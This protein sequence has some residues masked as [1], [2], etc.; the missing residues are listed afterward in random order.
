MLLRDKL[1]TINDHAEPLGLDP[2]PDHK[3][4]GIMGDNAAAVLDWGKSPV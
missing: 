4:Q 3:L 1:L 2:I